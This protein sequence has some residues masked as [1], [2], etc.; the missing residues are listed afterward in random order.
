MGKAH[1]AERGLPCILRL[2]LQLRLQ[3]GLVKVSFLSSPPGNP[4]TVDLL[5]LAGPHLLC[6]CSPEFLAPA[7]VAQLPGSFPS[8]TPVCVWPSC[9]H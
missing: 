8:P 9:S 4:R 5:P 3:V 1:R 6:L 2:T 7:P